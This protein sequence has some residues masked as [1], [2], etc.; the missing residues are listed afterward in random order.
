MTLDTMAGNVDHLQQPTLPVVL[1][2]GHCCVP[3][4]AV[5]SS[6]E[7]PQFLC[8]RPTDRETGQ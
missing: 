7:N 3:A 1:T 6:R 4:I 5:N 8:H 2:V